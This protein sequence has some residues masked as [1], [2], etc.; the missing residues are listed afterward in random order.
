V[1][2]TPEIVE[3]DWLSGVFPH[4]VFAIGERVPGAVVLE[5][6]GARAGAA[7]YYARVQSGDLERLLE[8]VSA[9][10]YVVDVNVTLARFG[11][12]PQAESPAAGVDE[13]EEAD[14]DALLDIAGTCFRYSRFHLDP[15]IPNEIAHAVKREWIRSYVEGRR[16]IQL[17]VAREQGRPLGFLAV[18]ASEL[19]GKHVRIIDLIGVATEEQG[20][21]IGRALVSAFAAEHAERCDELRVGT[22]IANVSSLR[23]YE[24]LGFS[25]VGSSYVLHLHAH[26]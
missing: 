7:M 6:A 21:G 24:A 4:P 25:V 22:Q 14:T 10:L 19:D 20:R 17:L 23:L 9:G 5:H 13:F 18:A 26:R 15:A 3:D 11:P 12:A 2:P 1:R 16:G 8:L